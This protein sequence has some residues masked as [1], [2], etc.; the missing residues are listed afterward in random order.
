MNLKIDLLLLMDRNGK[1]GNNDKIIIKY[2][3]G[4][5]NKINLLI[6]YNY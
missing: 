4:I 5:N 6:D 2:L 1:N 3:K